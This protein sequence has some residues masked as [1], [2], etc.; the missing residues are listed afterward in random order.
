MFCISKKFLLITILIATT[1]LSI[2]LLTKSNFSYKTSAANKS[3]FLKLQGGKDADRGE[4]PF[5]VALYDKSIF[6]SV[7]HNIRNVFF[8]G[9]VLIKPK[10]VL[11]AAHCLF[12]VYVDPRTGKKSLEPSIFASNIGIAINI[13][14]LKTD[15]D[16]PTVTNKYFMNAAID[17]IPHKDYFDFGGTV[18]IENDVALIKLN[19]EVPNT[20]TPISLA[21]FATKPKKDFIFLDTI[22]LGWGQLSPTSVRINEKLQEAVLSKVGFNSWRRSWLMSTPLDNPNTQAL[23]GDSGGPLIYKQ[24]SVN[25]LLGI[26]HGGERG[27]GYNEYVYAPDKKTWIDSTISTN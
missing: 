4:Y 7:T 22:P 17:P 6:D 9:G 1:F 5:M 13:I 10:W 25:T 23:R 20:V 18:H 3:A 14:N 24:N 8:C 12:V 27:D 26:T 19:S 16:D 15:Y 21:Y 2:F 11:T